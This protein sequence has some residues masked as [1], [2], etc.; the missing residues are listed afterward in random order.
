MSLAVNLSPDQAQTIIYSQLRTDGIPDPLAKLV[1]AQS[2]HETGGWASNVFMTDNNAFGYGFNGSA[3]KQYA[4]VEDSASDLSAYLNRRVN[5]GTFPPLD[6]ITD[7]GQY[8]TLLKNAGYYTDNEANYAA[9]ITSFFNGAL[10]WVGDNPL[11][12]G[13]SVASLV[14]LAVLAWFIFKK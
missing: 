6:Q 10:T 3:Y 11:T 2:G 8:A 12:A 7:P 4:S 14:G 13:I 9:G 1:T 5:D